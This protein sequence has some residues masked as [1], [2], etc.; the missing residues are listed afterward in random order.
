MQQWASRCS[1]AWLHGLRSAGTDHPVV[2]NRWTT[3][4]TSTWKAWMPPS[5]M[6]VGRTREPALR[7]CKHLVS[8]QSLH[9]MQKGAQLVLLS[10]KAVQQRPVMK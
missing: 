7:L 6:A 9:N 10:C 5:K 3:S 8:L 2:F 4:L 1:L